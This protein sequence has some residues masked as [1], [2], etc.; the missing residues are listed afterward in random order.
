MFCDWPEAHQSPANCKALG[1]PAF[2]GTMILGA[3]FGPEILPDTVLNGFAR[4]LDQRF[5]KS[6][7][8]PG[9]G[10]WEPGPG[11]PVRLSHFLRAT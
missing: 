10:F 2:L 7:A 9:L 1:T 3:L 8:E 11:G 5:N 6:L 4:L